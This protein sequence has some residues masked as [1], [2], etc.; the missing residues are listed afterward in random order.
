MKSHAWVALKYATE[1]RRI[2]CPGIEQL[3]YPARAVFRVVERL[4]GIF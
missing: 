3:D 4:V 2:S 1:P